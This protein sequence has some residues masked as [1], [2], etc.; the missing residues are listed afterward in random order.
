MDNYK[1]IFKSAKLRRFILNS[2]R[3]VPN[4]L[5]LKIQYKIKLKRKLNIKSPERF[6]EKI[7][8]YKL[9]YKNPI[10]HKCV[11]KYEVRKYVESL[12]LE[13]IL[14]KLYK[15][16]DSVEEID[17]DDLPNQ[18]VLK[19]THG[20]GGLNVLVCENKKDINYKEVQEKLLLG[21]KPFKS[22]SGGREWA[23]YGLKP[24]I[25]VEELLIN[26][27]NP[28]AGINDYKI[29]CFNGKPS[30][31]IVD[32]D[33]YVGH[34]R[35]FYDIE[36]NNLYITSDCPASNRNIEKP[37]NL[38]EMLNIA[39]KLS[40]DFPFVRVDLYNVDGKVYFGE[41]TFYPWSGYVQFEPDEFDYLLAKPLHLTK[42]K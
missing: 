39:A 29:L 12:G 30:Y 6:T 27:E 2:L 15:K 10:M 22:R 19:T 14:V 16:Y 37:D 11:D 33:R 18:F 31:I 7:Q 17:W 40:K 23:Y 28:T 25:V 21:N 32:I 38:D 9:N 5:M 8:W 36:W 34:K 35:N 42:F 20:G 13:R 3:I 24:G 4:S 1:K 26:K 41:L